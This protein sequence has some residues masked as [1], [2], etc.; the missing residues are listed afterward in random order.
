M[1]FRDTARF[2]VHAA[3]VL[4]CLVLVLCLQQTHA[5]KPGGGG[6]GVTHTSQIYFGYQGAI[7]RMF[8]DGSGK[9]QALPDGVSG[10]PSSQVYDGSRWWLT[11]SEVD[12]ET[13]GTSWELVAFRDDGTSVQITACAAGGVYLN[14]NA[15][16]AW[17]NDQLDTF[18]SISAAA[19][20]DDQGLK[21]YVVRL[22][23]IGDIELMQDLG[24]LPLTASDCEFVLPPQIDLTDYAWSSDPSKLAYKM[25]NLDGDGREVDHTI[26]VRTLPA[27]PDDEAVDQPIYTAARMFLGAWS[28]D[29][30]HISFSRPNSR[31][32][33]GVWT[34]RPEGSGAVQ[35]AT[36]SGTMT[37]YSHGWSPD[38]RELLIQSVKTSIDGYKYQLARMPAGGGK[39]TVLTSDLA[40]DSKVSFGWFVYP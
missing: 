32:W 25:I 2:G 17:S 39:L 27:D 22:P 23:I 36:N 10:V 11:L 6:G 18:V 9:T 5:A 7:W 12:G 26:W 19:D 24:L 16:P 28:P 37:F 8:E 15:Q 21:N 31:T 34:I 13:S 3:L 38:S 40:P 29:S 4:G 33:G 35:V 14:P 1:S 20:L 30:A